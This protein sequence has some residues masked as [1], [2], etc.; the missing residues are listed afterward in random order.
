[1]FTCFPLMLN[2]ISSAPTISL[3][4]E[5]I[6][7]WGIIHRAALIEQQSDAISFL[8]ERLLCTSEGQICALIP[9]ALLDSLTLS[10][11]E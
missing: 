6:A 2:F 7:H 1:M 8:L 4:W 11:G 3:C 10:Q 5:P 9:A